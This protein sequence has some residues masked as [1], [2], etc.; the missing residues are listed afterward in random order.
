LLAC[1]IV[2]C[3]D[4]PD[5]ESQQDPGT[6]PPVQPAEIS[7]PSVPPDDESWLPPGW[8]EDGPLSSVSAEQ[9]D[10]ITH[11]VAGRYEMQSARAVSAGPAGGF[12]YI[13]G[14]IEAEP[15]CWYDG[16]LYDREAFRE[17]YWDTLHSR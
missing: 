3:S 2:G 6:D 16:S 14:L 1:F 7:E 17:K 5:V 13:V 4:T 10:R 15:H 8:P 12:V 11:E 9:L